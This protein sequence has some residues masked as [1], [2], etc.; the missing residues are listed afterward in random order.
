MAEQKLPDSI[1]VE[2]LHPNGEPIKC[3][4]LSKEFIAEFKIPTTS[5]DKPFQI[6]VKKKY[7]KQTG[8]LYYD[9]SLDCIPF[10]DGLDTLI[11][12]EGTPIPMSKIHQ[13]GSGNNQRKG[14]Q[15]LQLTSFTY[16]ATIFLT[17]SKSPFFIKVHAHKS[18]DHSGQIQKYPHNIEIKT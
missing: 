9:G 4:E 12:I 17:Q 5:E 1:T 3:K 13:S 10:P 15:H 18:P 6:I 16:E 11:K 14:E 8:N 2:F 7:A